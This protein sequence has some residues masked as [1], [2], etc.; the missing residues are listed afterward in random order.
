[1]MSL[2]PENA[3]ERRFQYE[4]DPTFGMT[5]DALCRMAVEDDSDR[6]NVALDFFLFGIAIVIATDKGLTLFDPEHCSEIENGVRVKPRGMDEIE[7]PALVLKVE[8]EH[9][10]PCIE[11]GMLQNV[12][13]WLEE[14]ERAES[15]LQTWLEER[16]SR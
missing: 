9:P 13:P 11:F 10:A 16:S 15:R 14:W 12:D 3:K 2:A 5:M 7:I 6:I 8:E 4:T 1:M